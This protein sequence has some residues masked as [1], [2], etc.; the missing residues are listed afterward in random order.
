MHFK[1]KNLIICSMVLLLF[2]IGYAY[3]SFTE[4]RFMT[5]DYSL[6][7]ID[8][9]EAGQD[10]A[11][12]AADQVGVQKSSQILVGQDNGAANKDTATQKSSQ[13]L[14][15]SNDNKDEATQTSSAAVIIEPKEPIIET[16]ANASFF[17]EYR[18]E[19]DK[20]RSKEVEMW[21]SIINSTSTEKTFKELAQKELVKIVALTEKEM[22]IENLIVSRGFND[23]IVFLADDAATVIVDAKELNQANVAQIQD[24]VARNTKINPANIKIMKKN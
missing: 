19:R 9:S 20:N 17:S 15:G 1:R 14:V 8:R 7:I 6:D 12:A 10:A 24:I 13:I 22:K 4:N 5:N 23:A 21:E 18:M 16:S 3:N 11:P 2:I